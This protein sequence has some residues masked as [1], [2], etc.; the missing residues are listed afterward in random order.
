MCVMRH[1]NLLCKAVPEQ[2]IQNK[3]APIDNHNIV[4]DRIMFAGLIFFHFASNWP[5]QSAVTSFL[6][7]CGTAPLDSGEGWVRVG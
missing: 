6:V 7:H 2:A 3:E 1:M 5:K 4:A